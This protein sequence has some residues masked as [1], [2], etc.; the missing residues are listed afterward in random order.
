MQFF[1]LRLGKIEKAKQKIF[2]K[3]P[4]LQE[5]KHFLEK[6]FRQAAYVLSE[7]E[8][9]IINLKEDS[10]HMK[11]EQML[12]GF[13]SKEER[14]IVTE[15][16]KKEKLNFEQLISWTQSPKKNVRD[17][18]AKAVNDIFIKLLDTAEAEIN[19]I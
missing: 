5:Y 8:E 13:L 9:K 4:A 1:E 15:S 18:A 6:I 3:D 12:S 19:A 17:A 16:G 11:W 7:A 2:L 14:E 10:S